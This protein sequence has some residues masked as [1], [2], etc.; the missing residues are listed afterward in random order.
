M[1]SESYAAVPGI[2]GKAEL[3]PGRFDIGVFNVEG[4]ADLLA[5]RG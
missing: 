4:A 2:L 1:R 5:L 3:L